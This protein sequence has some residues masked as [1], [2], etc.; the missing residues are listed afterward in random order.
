[1]N[2]YKEQ[3]R[4]TRRGNLGSSDGVMLSQIANLGYVP[5]SAWKRMAVCKGLIEHQEIPRNAAIIA[6]DKLENIVYENLKLT[7]DRFESNPLWV[8]KKYSKK[9]VGLITHPDIVLKDDVNKTLNVYEVKCTKFNHIQT[10][11][12]YNAQLYIHTVIGKEIV[13]ELGRDWKLNVF[14]VCYSTDGLDLENDNFVFEPDRLT[15]KKIRFKAQHF[16]VNEAMTIVDNFLENFDYYSEDD[17]IP[18]EYLPTN[19][20]EQF[21]VIADTLREIQE[22]EQMLANFKDKLYKFLENKGIKSIKND[23][24]NITRILPTES[25]QFDHKA[26]IAELAEQHPRVYTRIMKKYRKCVKRNG[27]VS[28]KLKNN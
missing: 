13:A 1:M 5:K 21:D 19:I 24:F 17:I 16:D 6:G 4:D 12:T 23:V 11:H 20:K 10:R 22:K 26:Y 18:Y 9:N 27:Y 28:I 15:I 7:D 25:I 14:L 3:I 2:D 8:S